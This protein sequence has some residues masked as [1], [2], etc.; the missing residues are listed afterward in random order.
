MSSTDIA[1]FYST[2][3]SP[4]SVSATDTTATTIT[5]Q[6]GPVNRRDQ[7][8]NITGYSVR[9]R[10][11]NL[12]ISIGEITFTDLM[13]FT[14]YNIEV[15]A[16]NSVGVGV[17]SDTICR[18]TLNGCDYISFLQLKHLISQCFFCDLH[19]HTSCYWP[20]ESCV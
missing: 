16:M 7:N 8:G 3:W 4:T 17:Y 18:Q 20:R 9:Y 10:T 5:L 11:D 13:P 1:I 2:F 14:Y 6:W 12:Y 19:I 15:A